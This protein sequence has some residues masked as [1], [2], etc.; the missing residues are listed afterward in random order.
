MRNFLSWFRPIIGVPFYIV[1]MITIGWVIPGNTQ[2]LES[3]NVETL[4][5]IQVPGTVVVRE[6]RKL[7][8]PEPEVANLASFLNES[9]LRIPVEFSIT[10]D[11]DILAV[12]I[13]DT[14]KTRGIRSSVKPVKAERPPYPI[15]AREQGWEGTVVLRL[16]INPD[17]KVSSAEPRQSSGFPLLD[18][19]AVQAV[20]QWTFLPAK[21]GEFPITA[22]V[23]LPIRFD[24]DQ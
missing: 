18:E 20:Q 8:F 5:A 4:D 11:F 12:S 21:N 16:V 14:G 1:I 15:L 2:D 9:L 17:G 10:R 23:D 7:S 6:K 3:E 13:D 22:V 19:S 24:L